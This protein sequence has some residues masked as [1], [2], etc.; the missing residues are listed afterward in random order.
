MAPLSPGDW[1]IDVVVGCVV[2]EYERICRDGLLIKYM[3]G[4]FK[5]MC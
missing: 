4:S 3:K 1:K 2:S 5:R